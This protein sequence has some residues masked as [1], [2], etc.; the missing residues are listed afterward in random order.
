MVEGVINVVESGMAYSL[1]IHQNDPF[2][3]SSME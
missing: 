2:F 3:Q 1:T